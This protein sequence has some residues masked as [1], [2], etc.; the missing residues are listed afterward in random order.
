[1]IGPGDMMPFCAGMDVR[2]AFFS[3]DRQ[4]GRPALLLL[5]PGSAT[6]RAADATAA[7]GGIAARTEALDTDLLRLVPLGQ[8]PA[9]GV[10]GLPVVVVPDE[11]F[12]GRCGAP[13]G[14]ATLLLIDRASRV[15]GRWNAGTD[16]GGATSEALCFARRLAADP[17]REPPV[18]HV[19][20]LLEPALCAALIARF[21]EASFDSGLSFTLPDGRPSVR[22]DH[23]RKCRRDLLLEPDDPLHGRVIERLQG[24]LF[25]ALRRSLGCA[26]EF[27]DRI[28]L[29]RYDAVSGGHFARHRD[30]VAAATA[31]RQFALSVNLDANAH[32]GGDLRF[33]EF[34]DTRRHPATGEGFVFSASLLHEV[35]P[36]TRGTRHALL[37]FVHDA[38]AERRRRTRVVPSPSV[39]AEIVPAVR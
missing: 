18:L 22:V 15:V 9:T 26:A 21:E 36:V 12:F 25:P 20:G 32:D 6:A 35:T 34:C 5:C 1:M 28:M 10:D 4:A 30:N 17:A 16:P 24:R 29:A 11:S 13:T 33:P 19:P 14:E 37:T 23:A 3:S 39:P 31:F 7:L 38:E 8:G 2:G 27:H